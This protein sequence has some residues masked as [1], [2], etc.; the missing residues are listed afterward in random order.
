MERNFP[1]MLELWTEI[2]DRAD[3]SDTDRLKTLIRMSAAEMAAMLSHG[4]H[5]FAMSHSASSL[6]PAA[7]KQEEFS[8]VTQVR[9][10]LLTL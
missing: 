5:N 6:S 2:F 9:G 10:L 3:F 7:K 1:K 8:G 4:G